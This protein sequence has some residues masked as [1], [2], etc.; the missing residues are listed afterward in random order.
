[1]KTFCSKPLKYIQLVKLIFRENLRMVLVFL[2]K[3][4]EFYLHLNFLTVFMNFLLVM[5]FYNT[6]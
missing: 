6:I 5:D 2:K 1:M 3:R 4:R